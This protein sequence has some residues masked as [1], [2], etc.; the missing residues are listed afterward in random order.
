MNLKEL[1]L[2]SNGISDISI[3]EKVK[4]EKLENLGLNKNKIKDIN[5]LEKV[6]FKN[7]KELYLEYNNI[8]DISVLEKIKFDNLDNTNYNTVIE[9]YPQLMKFIVDSNINISK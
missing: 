9:F 6:N 5:V 7:L 3:L 8:S 2:S 4:F 1:D